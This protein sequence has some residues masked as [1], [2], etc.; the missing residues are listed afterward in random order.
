[1]PTLLICGAWLAFVAGQQAPTPIT[2]LQHSS[3]VESRQLNVTGARTQSHA[4]AGARTRSHALADLNLSNVLEGVDGAHSRLKTFASL[5]L[6]FNPVA[7]FNGLQP[8]KLNGPSPLVQQ[9]RSSNTEL[10]NG[11]LKNSLVDGDPGRAMLHSAVA[12]RRNR[13]AGRISPISMNVD[14]NLTFSRRDVARRAGDFAEFRTTSDPKVM[15][16]H[17]NV[18]AEH[19]GENSSQAAILNQDP[20]VLDDTAVASSVLD[21]EDAA[22]ARARL[23]LGVAAIGPDK[24]ELEHLWSSEMEKRKL[25][26]GYGFNG[27]L[28]E[29]SA[30]AHVEVAPAKQSWRGVDFSGFLC[31]VVS[32]VAARISLIM[33]R[34]ASPNDGYVAT[35]RGF[36]IDIPL[37]ACFV[38]WYLG[39]YFYNITNKLALNAAGG[40]AGFP[41]TIAT[42]QLAVGVAYSLF[43][44]AAPDARPR[45]KI[46]F[47]DYKQTLSVGFSSAGAHAAAVIALSAGA[48]SFAQTVKASEPVFAA[49]VGSLFYGVSTSTARWL[50]LIPVIGGVILTSLG[51]LN[52]SWSALV[53]AAFACL[54]SAIKGNE[55]KK[56]MSTPGISERLGSVGNQFAITMINALLFCLPV[57]VLTEGHK[58]GAFLNLC[59]TTPALFYNVIF[60]GLWFYL[61]NELATMTIKKTGAIAQSVANTAKRVIV[62][63]VVALAMG[64]SIGTLKLL[65]CSIAIG[66]V[67]LYSIID[68]IVPRKNVNK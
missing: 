67:F 14:T 62:I 46:T 3:Q 60:S 20:A 49:L 13:F 18:L 21:T 26:V 31:L 15:S 38:L 51:E 44:W 6:N 37:V 56:L 2:Q 40:V 54:F 4:L 29:A 10:S 9:P 16:T 42:M 19:L 43:L 36:S 66:G 24:A 47:A 11:M 30:D 58:F 39:F 27:A 45:P 28:P 12:G 22:K 5:L 48:I 61:Y 55:N 17:R 7:G 34:R 33:R 63:F 32:K 41:M 53:A 52:F 59:Q 23:E 68:K 65:G 50:C 8:T 35:K 57:M 1:M 25:H 64:E